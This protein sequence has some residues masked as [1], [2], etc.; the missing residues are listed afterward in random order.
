[1]G[2]LTQLQGFNP[3]CAFWILSIQ[4][5]PFAQEY[6][7]ICPL[8]VSNGIYIYIYVCIYIYIYHSC[9]GHIFS[10][11]PQR[12]K[13]LE[14][15]LLSPRQRVTLLECAHKPEARE[16]GSNGSKQGTLPGRRR[17]SA[18]PESYACTVSQAGFCEAAGCL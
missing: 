5:L 15:S 1:M 11:V 4:K 8:L 12:L 16:K 6:L 9:H 2:W 13:Q 3:W 14:G 10:F 17:A 18:L 7:F